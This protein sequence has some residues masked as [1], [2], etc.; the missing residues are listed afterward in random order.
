MTKYVYKLTMDAS[1]AFYIGVTKNPTARFAAHRSELKWLKHGSHMFQ[2]AWTDS[3]STKLYMEIIEE[4]LDEEAMA[5]EVELLRLYS[6]DPNLKNTCV[7]SA[8]G[9]QF[10]RLADPEALRIKKSQIFSGVN[11]PMYGKTHTPEARQKIRTA[12]K[13]KTLGFKYGPMSEETKRKLSESKRGKRLGEENHFYGKKHSPESLKKMREWDRSK[14]NMTFV[15]PVQV[16]GVVYKSRAD[17][18]RALNIPAALMTYRLKH[19]ARY[20]TYKSLDTDN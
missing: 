18:C 12:L 9:I 17:A 4:A 1:P 20:P 7:N 3:C 10:D 16:D 13:G 14:S 11:N 8:K 19:P 15:K 6:S 5:K 2:K